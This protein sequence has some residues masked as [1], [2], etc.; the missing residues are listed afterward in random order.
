MRRGHLAAGRNQGRGLPEL[1]F[2]TVPGAVT[3]VT[4]RLK[5]PWAIPAATVEERIR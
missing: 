3:G 4:G 2:L 1:L 5:A